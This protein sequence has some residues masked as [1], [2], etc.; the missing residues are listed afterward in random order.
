MTDVKDTASP[1][2]NRVNAVLVKQ[3]YMRSNIAILATVVNAALLV[4]I[5]RWQIPAWNLVIWFA[6]ILLTSISRFFLNLKF[7]RAD[8]QEKNSRR[9]TCVLFWGISIPGVLWGGT[10]L[11]LFPVHSVAH[12][13]FIAFVLSGMVAGAVGVFSAVIPVFLAFSIP[14]LTPITIRFLSLG[15]DLH[16]A[17]GGM[18]ILFAGL[19]FTTARRI[20]HSTRELV[21]LQEA[22]ADKL[23]QRTSELANANRQLKKE[24]EDRKRAEQALADS[25]Q[26]LNDIIEFLP[27]PTWVIN[28]SGC[29]IAWNRAIERITGINQKDILGKGNYAHAIPLYGRPRPMLIDLAL[30]RDKQWEA[31]HLSVKEENGIL[32]ASE[33]FHPSMGQDGRYFA[34]TASRLVDAQ[35][36]VVGAIQSMRDITDAKR[37]EKEREQLIEKL[38]D[39]IDKARTLS[40]LLPICASCKKIRDDKGYWKQIEN[41]ISEHSEAEFSHSICPD[42]ARKLY[43]DFLPPDKK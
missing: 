31:D 7:L 40:G 42:C 30:K 15:D 9:W 11:F 38:Q 17:M 24:V 28:T 20:S 33:S 39:A 37:M 16:L 22:F 36:Q 27:D 10:A 6:L 34:S 23:E 41:F 2:T 12:Q 5:L 19:T 18:T 13:A 29:V 25:R 26:R 1:M 21:E 32:I 35:G 43:P 4:F 14:A 3:I 8:D